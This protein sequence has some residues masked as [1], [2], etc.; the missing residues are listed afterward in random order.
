VAFFGIGA[1]VTVVLSLGPGSDLTDAPQ[2]AGWPA[3]ASVILAGCAIFLCERWLQNYLWGLIAALVFCLH[4]YVL[5]WA[6]RGEILLWA[7]ALGL[8]VLVANIAAWR[9]LFQKQFVPLAWAAIGLILALGIGFAWSVDRGSRVFPLDLRMGLVTGLLTM[10]AM[11]LGSILACSKRKQSSLCWGNI[12]VAALLGILCPLLGLAI[13]VHRQL[14]FDS[15][16]QA[17]NAPVTWDNCLAFLELT[18]LPNTDNR[19][20]LGLMVTEMERW[21]V[22]A[23]LTVAMMA[24]GFWR[25]LRRGWKCRRGNQPPLAWV[26]TLFVVIDLAGI[27]LHPPREASIALLSFAPVAVLLNV[28]GIADLAQGL[29]ERLVLAPPQGR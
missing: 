13:A 12:S 25:S 26:L 19:G 10:G 21:G 29:G 22:M 18:F 7:E 15:L 28:F 23:I 27:A 6:N 1:L 4:P 2:G 14:E 5:G 17:H 16:S 20:D 8:M 11:L 3:I 24:V 9:V